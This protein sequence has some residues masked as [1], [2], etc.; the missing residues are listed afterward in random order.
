M[1]ARRN[2]RRRAWAQRIVL[3]LLLAAVA[4][5]IIARTAAEP[6]V[7]EVLSAPD[8]TPQESAVFGM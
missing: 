8:L 2:Y 3:A 1:R 6:M 4:T 7:G 5:V